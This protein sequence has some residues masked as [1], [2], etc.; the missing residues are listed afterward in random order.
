MSVVT[1]DHTF[2]FA[3]VAT[4][5]PTAKV[6]GAGVGFGGVVTGTFDTV[7]PVR[8]I[9]GTVSD[10]EN[11]TEHAAGAFTWNGTIRPP[12]PFVEVAALEGGV[13]ARSGAKLA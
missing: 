12:V 11:A 5:A 9:S 1:D 8:L 6:S 13:C 4:R 2:A 10:D 7:H 3:V